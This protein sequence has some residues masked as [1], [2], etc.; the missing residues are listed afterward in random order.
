[1]E[2]EVTYSRTAYNN[3]SGGQTGDKSALAFLL[4][5]YGSRRL[6][7]TERRLNRL[8]RLLKCLLNLLNYGSSS[9]FNRLLNRLNYGS[10][11]LFNR[12]LNR[13]NYGSS[14]LFNCL[15]NRLNYG[16]SSLFNR[17]PN[18]LNNGSRSLFNCLPNRLNY[19]SSSLFG[20]AG[21]GTARGAELSSV[22]Y[23][24]STI[25]TKHYVFL[26]PK[27]I[28]EIIP[29][30]SITLKRLYVKKIPHKVCAVKQYIN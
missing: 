27:T 21:G 7:I 8:Y 13:L 25:S 4:G 2:S 18:R 3:R 29:L 28:P 1:M 24:T 9:L 11:S 15:P 12:L 26:S 20:N 6:C 17:L 22:L 30:Y 16:S 19:G 14:S 5:F 23:L 10:S